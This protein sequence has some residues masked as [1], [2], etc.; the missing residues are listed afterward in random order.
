MFDNYQMQ[1]LFD[2]MFEQPGQPRPHY[3]GIAERLGGLGRE[4]FAKRVRMADLTFRNQG[5]TFTV[6]SDQKGVEKIFP[7]DL[8]PR[9]VPHPEWEQIEKEKEVFRETHDLNDLCL[10]N[11]APP[12]WRSGDPLPREWERSKRNEATDEDLTW[13]QGSPVEYTAKQKADYDA[14]LL[15]Q[16]RKKSESDASSSRGGQEPESP[17]KG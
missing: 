2:E 5:I 4:E 1:G 12:N 3:A 14:Y 13:T 11:H 17:E 16:Q 9:I 15:R 7:F 8:V 10:P 6:Y